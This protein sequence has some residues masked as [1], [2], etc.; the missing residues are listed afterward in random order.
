MNIGIKLSRLKTE[1][2]IWFVYAF[3][4]I[5]ALY[6]NHLEEDYYTKKDKQAFYK[7]KAINI[8]VLTIAFFIYLYFVLII[9]EDLNNM[10]KNLQNKDYLITLAK[11]VGAILFLIGGAIQVISEITQTEPDEIGFI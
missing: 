5:A 6:S 10:E 4:V 3:I 2:F 7:Q 9:T 11:L 1:N 8:T